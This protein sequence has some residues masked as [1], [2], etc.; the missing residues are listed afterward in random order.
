MTKSEFRNEMDRLCRAFNQA[1]LGDDR[2]AAMYTRFGD[3]A[4]THWQRVMEACLCDDR[5][6][7]AS[8]LEQLVDEHR[9]QVVV[10]VGPP[11]AIGS[12]GIDW[13]D[14]FDTKDAMQRFAALRDQ[15]TAM[16]QERHLTD[17]DVLELLRCH[18]DDPEVGRGV[19]WHYE[20]LLARSGPY[21]HPEPRD[22]PPP[23][24]LY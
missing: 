24:S 5:Y 12:D 3:V 6:P 17:T 7:T 4:L 16:R 8:K 1:E 19:Q 11:K 21:Q 18:L 23:E 9:Q 2:L 13:Y 14:F 15:I 10:P 20:R 22:R